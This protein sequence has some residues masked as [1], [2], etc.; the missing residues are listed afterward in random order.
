MFCFHLSRPLIWPPASQ[1]RKMLW[2]RVPVGKDGQGLGQ[3]IWHRHSQGPALMR[4]A[5][6]RDRHLR[7]LY[8]FPGTA[9]CR[10][11]EGTAMHRAAGPP[12]WHSHVMSISMHIC[13]A[14]RRL[15]GSHWERSQ[16]QVLCLCRWMSSASVVQDAPPLRPSPGSLWGFSGRSGGG[17]GPVWARAAGL[18]LRAAAQALLWDSAL[19]PRNL[20]APFYWGCQVLAW[21]FPGLLIALLSLLP[22]ILVYFLAQIVKDFNFS[23]KV[24]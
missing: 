7:T 4:P 8:S 3:V 13:C 20:A 10:V 2:P 5:L 11:G 6:G 16:V 24:S 1:D 12:C 21:H 22:R 15:P 18:S 23:Y 17:A 9:P 14:R 19:H